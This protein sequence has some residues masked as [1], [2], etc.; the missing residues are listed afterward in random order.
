H[1]EKARVDVR[2]QRFIDADRHTQRFEAL[3]IPL[4]TRRAIGDGF[5][6]TINSLHFAMVNQHGNP[7]N[8]DQLTTVWRV[9]KELRNAPFISFDKSI[10]W[11][12]EIEECGLRVDP[13]ALA[14]LIEDFES[15]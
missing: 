1:V 8:F 12:S 10:D 5:A 6:S 15:E 13:P 3:L 11:A 7:L 4:F 9:L 14:N 2:A